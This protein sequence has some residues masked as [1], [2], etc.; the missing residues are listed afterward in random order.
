MTIHLLGTA[1]AEGWPAPFCTCDA[2]AASRRAG[3]WNVRTRSGA[4]IDSD[5]K[6]DFG[7]DT[8]MQLQR[9]GRSIETLR[10]IVFTH[11]HSDH[12]IPTELGWM[13]RPFTNTPPAEP[14]AIYGNSKVLQLIRAAAQAE[15]DTGARLHELRP[16]V[17]A[18]TSTGDTILP[19]PADHAEGALVLRISRRGKTLF[20]GHD[21]GLYPEPT[22]D[23]LSDGVVLD[24]ALMDCTNGAMESS[25]R[26]HMGVD[27][28]MRMAQELRRRGAITAKT[29]VVATHFSHNGKALHEELVRLFE[30]HGIEVAYD[31]MSITV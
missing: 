28:V 29:R 9:D 7:A 4:I 3:G 5:L 27:G 25:N 1:A 6:V 17:A 8:L 20:Y 22:L 23:A 18:T 24:V 31:A 16:F 15:G 13:R 21:S 10:T 2:C 12:I 26:G 30:P 11:E 14:V 19:L